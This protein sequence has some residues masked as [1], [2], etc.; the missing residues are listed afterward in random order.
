ML[1]LGGIW[2]ASNSKTL[3]M[4]EAAVLPGTILSGLAGSITLTT[5]HELMRKREPRAPRMD[6]LGMQALSKLLNSVGWKVPGRQALFGW[7]L[8]GDLGT[9]AFYYSLIAR[10]SQRHIWLKGAMLGLAAGVGAVLLPGRLGLDEKPSSRSTFTMLA[11]MAIYLAGGL[12]A[13]G[14]A[15]NIANREEAADPKI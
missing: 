2:I 13:A 11:T 14:V 5:L 10:G 12:V 15:R 6:L 4:K 7:T 9:N 1:F 3:A 8:F